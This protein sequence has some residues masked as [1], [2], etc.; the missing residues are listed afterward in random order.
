MVSLR[1]GGGAELT[2]TE[3]AEIL[4]GNTYLFEGREDAGIRTLD[5]QRC[6]DLT[7]NVQGFLAICDELPT[8]N[9]HS[10]QK[11]GYLREM[12]H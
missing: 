10:R 7:M 12:P 1:G 8:E 3:L 4:W 6:K 2:E 5:G 9:S 11:V